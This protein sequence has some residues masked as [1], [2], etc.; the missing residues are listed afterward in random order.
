MISSNEI[1][2]EEKSTEMVD[3]GLA[4]R[5]RPRPT[6]ARG[7]GELAGAARDSRG[8]GLG[9]SGG[10]EH[11]GHGQD[12]HCVPRPAERGNQERQGLLSP[13]HLSLYLSISIYLPPDSVCRFPCA[14]GC[15]AGLQANF[16]KTVRAALKK[17]LPFY[18][19]PTFLVPVLP[20]PLRKEL[21]SFPSPMETTKS[22]G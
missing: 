17:R 14:E 8:V 22:Y 6:R 10:W 15:G 18:M 3:P 11:R 20:P 16:K 12:A 21:F 4:R 2:D 19:V 7:G 1:L 13:L 5:L 9:G